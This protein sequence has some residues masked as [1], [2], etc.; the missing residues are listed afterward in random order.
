MGETG[1]LFQPKK[2][3]TSYADPA[4]FPHPDP[5]FFFYWG[6]L[7]SGDRFEPDVSNQ[8]SIM[9]LSEIPKYYGSPVSSLWSQ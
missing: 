8:C 4:S 2:I 7:S 9:R 1:S 5:D 3:S 6:D